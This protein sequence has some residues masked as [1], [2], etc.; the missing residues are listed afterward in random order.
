MFDPVIQHRLVMLLVH[1][2]VPGWR[3]RANAVLTFYLDQDC[4]QLP[5]RSSWQIPTGLPATEEGSE[6]HP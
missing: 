3:E 5:C 6:C 2:Q 1:L 4:L